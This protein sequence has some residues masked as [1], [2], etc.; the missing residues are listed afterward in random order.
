MRSGKPR[1]FGLCVFF[2]VCFCLSLLACDRQ[3]D[4]EAF[5]DL[6]PLAD[7]LKAYDAVLVELG[8][9]QG[10]P[11]DTLFQGKVDAQTALGTLPAPHYR[12][13]NALISISGF[14]AGK[15]VYR[16]DR[17]YDGAQ[18]RTRSV[19]SRLSPDAAVHI[20]GNDTQITVGDSAPLP[21]VR[22]VPEN[23]A[24]KRITWKSPESLK[25]AISG[26]QYHALKPGAAVL[27]VSLDSDP[28]KKSSFTVTVK[29][30]YPGR[31]PEN[32]RIIPD[33]LVVS[34][35][36]RPRALTAILTPSQASP[37]LAWGLGDAAM[38]S[39]DEEGIVRGLSPGTTRVWAA[40]RLA[41][42]I[43]DSAW[44]RILP[45]AGV[46]SVRFAADSSRIYIG[47]IRDSLPVR[48]FPDWADSA[49]EWSIG[50]GT[51]AKFQGGLLT[52]TA[53]GKTWV[54][55][56]SKSY[57]NRTDTLRLTV[58]EKIKVD[59][60]NIAQDT[61]R[62]YT[63]G[64]SKAFQGTSAPPGAGR[65]RWFSRQLAVATVD[66][67]GSV[68]PI[69]PGSA[70]IVA[71]NE[72]D[73]SKRDSGI[74]FVKR[75]VPRLNV[76][77]D[78]VLALGKT[79]DFAPVAPQEY[80]SIVRF[81]WDLDG[82]GAWD[83]SAAAL[84]NLSKAYPEAKEWAPRFY[85]RD[86]EGNDSLV[87]VKVK[88]TQGRI[89]RILQPADQAS[90][91]VAE[92]PV[93]WSIDDILQSTG[94]SQPLTEGPNRIVRVAPGGS[95]I[96]DSAVITVYLDTHPPEKPNV[97]GPAYSA[98]KSPAWTWKGG[99]GG[100]GWF[101][102]R[103]DSEVLEGQPETQDTLYRPILDL[104]E[105]KHTLIVQERDAAGNWSAGGYF[106]IN[107]D[108]KGPSAPV[109]AAKEVAVPDPARPAWVWTGDAAG[110]TGVFRVRIDDEDFSRGTDTVNGTE[111]R[112][113]RDLP[114]GLHTLYVQE[115][116]SAG[117]WS[118]AG[119]ASIRKTGRTGYIV[120]ELGIIMKTT[121]EGSSWQWK[122]GGTFFGSCIVGPNSMYLVGGRGSILRSDNGGASWGAQSSGTTQGLYAIARG[123][124]FVAVGAGGTILRSNAAGT[125]WT[126]V[127]SGT[128][129]DLWSVAFPSDDT[130]FAFGDEGTILKTV[131]GGATW[132]SKGNETIR[133]QFLGSSFLDP[134][135][136]YVAGGVRIYKTTDGGETW[137]QSGVAIG[138]AHAGI[139]FPT[140]DTGYAVGDR[141]AIFKTVN[142]GG[143]WTALTSGTAENL[144]GVD[145]VS[146]KVGYVSG[147][148]GVL[149]KT[150]DG[151]ATWTPQASGTT[152]G[153]FTLA[154]FNANAGV[155]AGNG[156][157]IT[158]TLDGGAA[159][160]P[161]SQGA[162]APLFTQHFG[163][164]NTGFIGGALGLILKTADGADALAPV[165]S[166][167]AQSLRGAY[168]DR[169]TGYLVGDGGVILKTAN[170]ASSFSALTSG[171]TQPLNSV[172]FTDSAT[173]YAAGA[174]GTILK[175]G[176][177]GGTWAAL[178]SGTVKE[179]FAVSFVNAGTGYAAGAGG[180]LLKTANAGAA[181]APLASGTVQALRSLCF[182]S[183]ATGYAVGDAGV[184]L[185]TADGGAKWSA[186]VSGTTENLRSVWFT[187][188]STGIAVGSTG[189]ILRTANGGTLWSAA[190][191]AFCYEY[192]SAFF[193]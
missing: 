177:G 121:D 157:T 141:G 148:H 174:G 137:V 97:T 8:T 108:T 92:I 21:G 75:D 17:T 24:D 41:P 173:G 72:A 95:G 43:S 56:R 81:K 184:I 11:L 115:R 186:Q 6:R 116:D 100:S 59:S 18:R 76:G 140:W 67:S 166:G 183:P 181:W 135:T 149:L 31:P 104:S 101:R 45:E 167:T 153:L 82:D 139:D 145:F 179:L 77:R 192:N 52:A 25:V 191:C 159:W 53:P 122:A 23:L 32:V 126:A 175:T 151:G 172:L 87:V 37:A 86:S 44:V 5:F 36:G 109:V 138:N 15:L 91:R 103:L 111:Y 39:I 51:L 57:P 93:S 96:P 58:L 16:T 193:P 156:G 158:A 128:I 119:S 88:V 154:F 105:G 74:A 27:I 46:D 164:A 110:G 63:G 80:G 123:K 107:I 189:T 78:T 176:N 133:T 188:A 30:R 70:V 60:V 98:A 1:S 47:G 33:T 136:G 71:V 180:T 12:G 120:G 54:A 147:D 84:R 127:P 102:Y 129:R 64:E 7:T 160:K 40:S 22:V 190:P 26:S 106:T 55:A 10:D 165:A 61:L 162:E 182:T 113:A 79:L 117:N 150:V 169:T 131:D 50:D 152:H 89:V 9:P 185:K 163:A 29:A 48:V 114:G 20:A 130:G 168:S 132:K 94:T 14:V 134:S 38:A 143:T 69:A 142:A 146:A 171:T 42:E 73:S 83:D 34:V 90:F 155:A 13:G 3:A 99:G 170:G 161:F 28:L 66:Q 35:R 2:S 124:T 49:L 178:P 62:L 68:S 187:D 125:G 112:S 85:V 144:G 4:P 118:A 19:V 65:L